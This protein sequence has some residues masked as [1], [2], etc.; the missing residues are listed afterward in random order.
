LYHY[1]VRDDVKGI[2]LGVLFEP[3]SRFANVNQ[4]Y[5]KTKRGPS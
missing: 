4:W 5:I 3:S 1:Y 2:A